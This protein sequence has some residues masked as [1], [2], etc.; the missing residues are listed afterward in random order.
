MSPQESLQKLKPQFETQCVE[1]VTNLKQSCEAKKIGGRF[2]T[3]AMFL[4]L[5]LEFID[6]LNDNEKLQVMP[7]MD[8]IVRIELEQI[9][10]QLFMSVRDQIEKEFDQSKMPFSNEYLAERK[11]AY[12]KSS[13]RFLGQKLGLLVDCPNL[14][15]IT[16][17]LHRRI[18]GYF[19]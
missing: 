7:S 10:D 18:N 17:E 1:L 8:K 16:E 15:E 4:N 12:M 6:Q 13:G 9:S 19:Y 14:I 3:G 5:A 11:N 2:L